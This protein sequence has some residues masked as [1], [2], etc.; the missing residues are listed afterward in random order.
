[1]RV[2]ERLIVVRRTR[3]AARRAAGGAVVTVCIAAAAGAT[4]SAASTFGV[5]FGPDQTAATWTGPQHP[6]QTFVIPPG[7]SLLRHVGLGV[8][9]PNRLLQLAVAR[10]TGPT[11]LGP[12]LWSGP[13]VADPPPNTMVAAPLNLRVVPGG[14]YV[15]YA[16]RMAP[17]PTYLAE[18]PGTLYADGGLSDVSADGTTLRDGLFNGATDAVFEVTTQAV[19][20]TA[21]VSTLVF[22]RQA[23]AT[24]GPARDVV[25]RNVSGAP[26]AVRRALVRGADRD[27]VLVTDDGC[28]ATT[29]A[30]DATCTV[31]VR[32]APAEDADRPTRTAMLGLMTDDTPATAELTA[33]TGDIGALPAGPAGPTG[34]QGPDGPSGAPGATGAQGAAGAAGATGATGPQGPDGAP[35]APGTTGASGADGQDGPPG[36]PGATGEKGATGE[37]GLPGVPGPSGPLGLRGRNGSNG[38]TA[39]YRCTPRKSG[40][41]RCVVELS[42]SSATRTVSVRVTRGSRTVA[43]GSRTLRPDQRPR[44]VLVAKAAARPGTYRIRIRVSQRGERTQTLTSTFRAASGTQATR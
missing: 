26:L 2:P 8:V 29:L 1:M 10:V 43:A 19:P 38:I 20:V 11:T 15:V 12:E 21:S 3:R 41:A 39:V 37:R 14:R 30:V 5:P 25:M 18:R 23:A 9:G 32:F 24:I 27:D 22:P 13:I 40:D 4:P 31:T 16:R 6:G 36:A 34:P 42:G 17:G 35:G 28:A 44:V 7:E 33:L